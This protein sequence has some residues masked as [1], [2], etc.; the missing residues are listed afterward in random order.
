MIEVLLVDLNGLV[1]VLRPPNIT[2]KTQIGLF[3]FMVL[4]VNIGSEPYFWEILNTHS[5][6]KLSMA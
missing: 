1:V 4:W 6:N 3:Y 5:S 2:I